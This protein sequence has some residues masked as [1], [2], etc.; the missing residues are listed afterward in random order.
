MAANSFRPPKPWTLTEDESVTSYASWHS[1][2]IYH[3]SLCNEFAHFLESEWSPK[4]VTNHGLVND[5]NTVPEASRKTAVQKSIILDRML[6]WIAQY[7]PVYLRNEI[8]KDSTSLAW[9]WTRIRRHYGFV[10]SEVHFLALSEI[11]RKD[12]E[13]Y[14]T[15]FQRIR[16]HID[17]NLLTISSGIHHNGAAVTQDEVMSPSTERLAV[18]LWLTLIDERLPAY[19]ARVYAHDLASKSLKDIQPQISRSMDALLADLS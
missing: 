5:A 9:I 2:C 7:A 4:S 14:E 3:L 16:C 10:Q 6:G 8:I 18:Y 12:D 19:I 17:D 1:N 11:K 15:F 13:R